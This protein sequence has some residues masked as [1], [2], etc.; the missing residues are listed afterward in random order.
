MNGT[1]TLVG[2]ATGTTETVSVDVKVAIPLIG[3]KLEG[4]VGDM[5]P[6]GAARREQGRP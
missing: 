5:L 4:F 3:G 2:D 6:Q 1:I